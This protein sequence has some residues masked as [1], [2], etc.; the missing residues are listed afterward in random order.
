M[1]NQKLQVCFENI[2]TDIKHVVVGLADSMWT[3][4][5]TIS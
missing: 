1:L 5:L 4:R 2:T 3:P